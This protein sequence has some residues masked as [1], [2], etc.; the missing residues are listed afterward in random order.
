MYELGEDYIEAMRPQ[1]VQTKTVEKSNYI[2][3]E[4]S[5]NGD[6]EPINIITKP[7]WTGKKNN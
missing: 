7:I 3:C 4:C 2:V 6:R 5:R 1:G